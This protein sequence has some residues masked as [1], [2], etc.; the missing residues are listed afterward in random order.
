MKNTN[1][2][3]PI[4]LISDS[5]QLIGLSVAIINLLETAKR[6]TFYEIYLL[7]DNSVSDKDIELIKNIE[8]NYKNGKIIPIK[9]KNPFKD[10]KNQHD[11]V[12]NADLFKL[13]MASTLPN[14]DKVLYLDTDILIREDLSDLF[15]T[16][17][18]NNY[19]GGVHSFAHAFVLP[20]L[21]KTLD[22][23]NL[24]NYT[25][26]G[27]LL[28]N[29][30]KIRQDNLEHELHKYIGK[31]KGS[32]DQHLVNKVCYGKIK[33]V[34]HKYNWTITMEN[35]YLQDEY[36]PYSK[37]YMD[38]VYKNPAIYHTTGP[39]KYWNCS[40]LRF[41][42]EWY[43]YF[44][45]SPYRDNQE[46]NRIY[47][48]NKSKLDLDLQ[49]LF[50]GKRLKK[51]L[52]CLKKSKYERI[53]AKR[54]SWDITRKEKLYL[55]SKYYKERTGK[56]LNI[57]NPKTFSEKIQWLKMNYHNPL[58]TICSDKYLVRDYIKEKIGNEYLIPQLG[59]WDKPEDIDF[60]RLPTQFV[61]KVNWGSGQNIIVTDKS[62]LDIKEAKEKLSN[63]LLPQQNNYY[64][65]I[66]WAYKNIQ[67]K[68]I[69]EKYLEN[70]EQ[71]LDYK[72]MCYNG[73]CKNMFVCSNR[74]TSLNV[75]F[76]DTKYNHLPFKRKFENALIEPKKPKYFDKMIELSETLAKPFPFVRVDW[77]EHNDKIYFGE[78]TFY[79]GNGME[80]FEPQ[81]WDLKLGSLLNLKQK[82]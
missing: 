71:I 31:F 46:I 81:E 22:I 41:S 52:L 42:K 43:K 20:T 23:P 58:I 40:N 15:N 67:P 53:N 6:K 37:N 32:V 51:S 34:N 50:F 56:S 49:I 72:F 38:T 27:V 10:M 19:L 73:I 16:D 59:V 2:T 82:D 33:N 7:L 76:F 69:A 65:G 57:K 75:D 61:L 18:E 60:D 1:N 3:I 8:K 55:L 9:I 11:Y 47:S 64:R 44:K 77:Y 63:W 45:K 4:A 48:S 54:Y 68:I 24:D 62:K 12:S 70:A 13:I 78:L 21:N 17:L 5:K 79:P 14:L 26:C 36:Y 25:G 39:N 74:R 29:L 30:K 80:K 66:E 28:F 35:S